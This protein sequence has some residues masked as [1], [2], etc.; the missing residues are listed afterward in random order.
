MEVKYEL[1]PLDA[2]FPYIVLSE[3]ESDPGPSIDIIDC[4]LLIFSIW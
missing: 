3:A 1:T 2:W 4:H